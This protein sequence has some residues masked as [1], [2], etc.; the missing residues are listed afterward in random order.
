MVDRFSIDFRYI[1]EFKQIL[2]NSGSIWDQFGG[3][4]ESLWRCFWYTR[5]ALGHFWVTLGPFWAYDGYICG[6]GGA[7]K[8]KDWKSM[9]FQSG[10]TNDQQRPAKQCTASST[11]RP[12]APRATSRKPSVPPER[13]IDY[14]I[15]WAGGMH[16]TNRFVLEFFIVSYWG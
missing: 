13:P 4:L 3:T 7:R 10:P 6:P 5:M 2:C 12:A 9:A 14:N 11:Q 15:A 16:F 1:A 8:R